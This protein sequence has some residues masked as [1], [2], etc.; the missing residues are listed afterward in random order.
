MVEEKAITALKLKANKKS[1]PPFAHQD[2]A[3]ARNYQLK[4][5]AGERLMQKLEELATRGA[6]KSCTPKLKA[7]D[8]GVKYGKS[9]LRN[10]GLGAPKKEDD[11]RA[12]PSRQPSIPPSVEALRSGTV[13]GFVWLES[14]DAAEK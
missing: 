8:E 13:E 12:Q 4:T 5:G 3:F 11:W 9:V 14:K 7:A 6:A 1:T 2:V 10:K